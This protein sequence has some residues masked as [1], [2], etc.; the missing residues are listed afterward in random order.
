MKLNNEVTKTS[1]FKNFLESLTWVA[2]QNWFEGQVGF[3]S[4]I[5]DESDI[6]ATIMD[7]YNPHEVTLPLPVPNLSQQM[8]VVPCDG[9]PLRSIGR[10]ISKLH[11]QIGI[12]QVNF[13]G[14]GYRVL[15]GLSEK[16]PPTK[17]LNQ[18]LWAHNERLA[19][20]PKH[21][22]L[23]YCFPSNLD[24]QAFLTNNKSDEMNNFNHKLFQAH[25]NLNLWLPNGVRLQTLKEP[26]VVSAPNTWTDNLAQT[27]TIIFPGQGVLVAANDWNTA[28]TILVNLDKAAWKL[29]QWPATFQPRWSKDYVE[30][31]RDAFEETLAKTDKKKVEK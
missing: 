3:E 16:V 29:S 22:V 14:T 31:L 1:P 15:W 23:A 5:L 30:K 2:D 10:S 4:A 19:I 12:I 18:I 13:K 27:S 7:A 11:Q 6:W 28:I 25:P 26:F 24:A 17:F 8:I 9:R 20:N 21:R